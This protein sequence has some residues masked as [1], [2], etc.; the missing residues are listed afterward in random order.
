[1]AIKVLLTPGIAR[2]YW[3]RYQGSESDNALGVAMNNSQLKHIATTLSAF[4]F[5]E[6]WAFG[7]T[8]L[9][10]LPRDWMLVVVSALGFLNTQAFAVWVL[11]YVKDR[12]KIEE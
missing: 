2:V 1:M 4:A 3:A 5:A 10:G 8:G 9:N 7:Y 6:F 11:S 12:G